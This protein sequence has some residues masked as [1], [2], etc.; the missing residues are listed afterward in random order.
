MKAQTKRP[1]KLRHQWKSFIKNYFL[2]ILILLVGLSLRLWGI[3]HGMP[4]VYDPDEPNMVVLAGGMLGNRDFNPHW[5]GHPATTLIYMLAG[6]DVIIYVFGLLFGVFNSPEDFRIFYHNDPSI[7]YIGG[8]ILIVFF[9]VASIYLIF[10]ITEKVISKKA[11]YLAA[12]LLA[13]APLHVS[14]SKYVRSDILMTFFILLA[15]YICL[16]VLR[17]DSIWPYIWA[18]FFTGLG[19]VT[20]YPAAIFFPIIV[21]A[22]FLRNGLTLNKFNFLIFSGLACL[23]GMFIGSPYLFLDIK[24]AITNV[25]HE[26][27]SEHLGAD[28]LG[29]FGRLWFYVR[30]LAGQVLTWPGLIIAFIGGIFGVIKKNKPL[31]LAFTFIVLFLLSISALSLNWDRWVIPVIPFVCLLFT[32]VATQIMDLISLQKKVNPQKLSSVASLAILLIFLTLL[33]NTV[34]DSLTLAGE[35]TR[36]ITHRWMMDNLTPDSKILMEIYTPIFPKEAF[37]FYYVDS[38]GVLVRFDP[39]ESYKNIFKSPGHIGDLRDTLQIETEEIDYMIMGSMFTRY[40]SQIDKYQKQAD[41]YQQL[42]SQAEMI[43]KASPKRGSIAGPEVTVYS[44]I[45]H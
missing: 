31:I 28:T 37:S 10:R 34:M 3:D 43:F 22:H 9:S 26:S 23:V 6:L 39:G 44:F 15:F 11:G 19:I 1:L 12:L 40:L 27:R 24:T 25:L 29:Y 17:E 16:K 14:F 7:L 41:T 35:D 8:R 42:V 45:N 2:I 21:L 18:G 5:F 20:K 33:N 38:N 4:F 32:W 13:I 36:T 30:T